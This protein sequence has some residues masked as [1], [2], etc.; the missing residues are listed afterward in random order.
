MQ[1]PDLWGIL[2]IRAS[3]EERVVEEMRRPSLLPRDSRTKAVRVSQPA[4]LHGKGRAAPPGKNSPT[5]IEKEFSWSQFSACT[6]QGWSQN[7]KFAR[8]LPHR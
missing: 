1:R 3:R 8:S 6:D 5:E 2:A 7:I 4:Q